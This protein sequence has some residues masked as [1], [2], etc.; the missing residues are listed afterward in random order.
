LQI[1][2][3]AAV[4]N[5]EQFEELAAGHALHALEPADEQLFLIHLETCPE[6]RQSLAEFSELAAGLAMTSLDEPGAVPPPQ[7]WAGIKAHVATENVVPLQRR[8]SPRRAFAAA[9]AAL[10]LVAAGVIGW[11]VTRGNSSS[12]SVQSALRD[13]HRTTTCVAVQLTGATVEPGSTYLMIRGMDVQVATTSLPALDGSHTYVLWQMP[14]DGAPTG[15]LAFEAAK[16]HHATVAR[17]TLPRPY[18]NTAAFAI[19]REAGTTI[20]PKPSTPI[21]I[22]AATS[23]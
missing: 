5:H 7:V 22:G 4:T 2:G 20:P 14:Q 13:C 3:A 12:G 17:A 23:A 18:D 1:R 10:V 15:V 19:S 11:Q 16:G 21:A 6:C 9:A 8:K